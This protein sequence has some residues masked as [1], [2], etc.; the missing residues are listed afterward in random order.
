VSCA[1]SAGKIPGKPWPWVAELTNGG[2][3]SIV[4]CPTALG[5]DDPQ[6]IANTEEEPIET[7]EDQPI[8]NAEARPPGC[9]P[10]RTLICWRSSI[11]SAS[12]A[13]PDRG[14]PTSATPEDTLVTGLYATIRLEP[15]PKLLVDGFGR[16]EFC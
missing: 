13:A 4:N 5:L 16:I 10:L 2:L 6:R 1:T 9:C 15:R 12:I 8:D 11:F 14:S 3:L 7:D